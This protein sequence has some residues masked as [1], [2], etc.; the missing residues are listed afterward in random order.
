MSRENFTYPLSFF[1][2]FNLFPQ[3]L[4]L[5]SI[6]VPLYHGLQGMNSTQFLGGTTRTF[7]F[8]M[9]SISVLYFVNYFCSGLSWAW[10]PEIEGIFRHYCHLRGVTASSWLSICKSGVLTPVIISIYV[11]WCSFT[12]VSLS[13]HHQCTRKSHSLLPSWAPA[14]FSVQI[15]SLC[16]LSCSLLC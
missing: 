7:G 2:S 6:S 13:L 11:A 16:F 1:Y 15:T 12:E 8:Q 5:C 3:G 14:P 10:T 4:G 9:I